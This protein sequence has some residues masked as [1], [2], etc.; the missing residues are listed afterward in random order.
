M[1]NNFLPWSS[2]T[3]EERFFC[4]HLYHGILGKEKEFVKWLNSKTKLNLN[5]NTGW[6]ISFEVCFYRDYLKSIGKSVK[7]YSYSRNKLFPQKRTFDLCLFSQDHIVIIEAKVQQNF[8]EK[9][10]K[11][12][13]KDK[14]MVTEL[15]RRSD[16]SVKVDG[17]LLC[18]KEYSYEDKRFPVIY[19]SNVPDEFSNDIL[20]QADGKFKKKKVGR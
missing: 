15:L 4:S 6:E 7:K 11:D 12:L 5:E 13:I 14:K 1:R 9:Q 18:S 3:R 16:H 8:D 10:I 17:I 20:N 2:I 19:W